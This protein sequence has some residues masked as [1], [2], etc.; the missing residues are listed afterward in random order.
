MKKN[1]LLKKAYNKLKKDFD[2][3]W[4]S[5]NILLVYFGEEFPSAQIIYDDGHPDTLL[6]SVNTGCKD[7]PTIASLTLALMYIHNLMIAEP[8]YFDSRQKIFFGE[9]AYEVRDAEAAF[10]N[11]EDTTDKV[12]H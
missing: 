11:N 6:L 9:K 7:A 4:Y 10:N 12:F 3:E 2:M 8:F 5:G 1:E